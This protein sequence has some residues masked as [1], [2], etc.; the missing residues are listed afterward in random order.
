MDL[1]SPVRSLIRPGESVLVLLDSA[2]DREH[3]LNEL[4]AYS[5]L[6]SLG[7]YIVA[8]DG[9]MKDLADVPRGKAEWTWNNPADAA[10]EIVDRHPEFRID[11]PSWLFNESHLTNPVT[12]WPGAWLRRIAQ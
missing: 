4:S 6:V 3:V 1:S 10:A 9:L 7:S 8:L 5:P 11:P 2:H 12:Q